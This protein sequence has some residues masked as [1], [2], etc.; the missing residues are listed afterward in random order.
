MKNKTKNRLKL[1]LTVTVLS[2]CGY[3]GY[4][5]LGTPMA[6]QLTQMN[7]NQ[8]CDNHRMDQYIATK[9]LTTPLSAVQITKNAQSI[10]CVTI[11]NRG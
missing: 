8:S 2:G 9:K 4:T 6:T 5:S 1:L 3:V 10:Y 7:T 11:K